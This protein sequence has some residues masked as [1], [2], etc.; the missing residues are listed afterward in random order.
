MKWRGAWNL[1]Q[2]RRRAACT[3]LRQAADGPGR[4]EKSRRG[5]GPLVDVSGGPRTKKGGRDRHGE[6]TEQG[7][8]KKGTAHARRTQK[9]PALAAHPAVAGAL[10]SASPSTAFNC[11][12]SKNA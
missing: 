2:R 11:F 3:S 9:T 4:P 5:K 1:R 10:G 6:G 7:R 8:M 12:R